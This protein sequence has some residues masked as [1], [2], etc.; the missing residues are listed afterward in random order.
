MV[1]GMHDFTELDDATL[2]GI[3]GGDLFADLEQLVMSLLRGV[4]G[5]GAPSSPSAPATGGEFDPDTAPAGEKDQKT[6]KEM[7]CSEVFAK[8][9]CSQKCVGALLGDWKRLKGR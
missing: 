2:S 9:H 3:H 7:T 5:S 1:D 4:Q 8:G 6:G